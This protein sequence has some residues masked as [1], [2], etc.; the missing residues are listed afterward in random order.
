MKDQAP[1]PSTAGVPT[2]DAEAGPLLFTEPSAG[3]GGKQGRGDVGFW[4]SW[5]SSSEAV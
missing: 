5:S 1:L 3:P 2:S 4:G